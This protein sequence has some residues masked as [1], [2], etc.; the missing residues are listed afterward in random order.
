MAASRRSARIATTELSE[1]LTLAGR[2]YGNFYQFNDSAPEIGSSPLDTAGTAQ[3]IGAELRGRYEII[4]PNKLGI[5]AGAEASYNHTRSTAE[6]EGGT[7]GKLADDPFVYDVEGTYAEIDAQ[8]TSWLAFTGGIRHDLRYDGNAKLTNRVSPRLAVFF[9][10]PERYG[11]KLLY[12]E[13]FRNPSAFEGVFDDQSD[14]VANPD[15][16]PEWIRSF[17][18][19]AWAKPQPGI[20]LRLSGFYWGIHDVIEQRPDP[21]NPMLL[22]FQNITRYV[23]Q[24]I[25]GEGSYRD[26]RGWYAFGGLA[27]T[28]V[29]SAEGTK[30]VAYGNV[31]NAPEITASAGVSTPKLF[32]RVHVSA[33]IV[34]LGERPTRPD[35]TGAASPPSPAWAGWNATIYAP[36]LAGFE[37]TAGVRNILGTRDLVPAPGDYDRTVMGGATQFVVARVPGEGREV[38]VKIGYS[39]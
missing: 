9:A 18:V 37:V 39:Y 28:H 11:V 21:M 29:G 1:R 35:A 8:P 38:Y 6:L 25:E 2:I 12:A 34:V 22:Q 32:D 3:V 16:S 4:A 5:T 30:A 19:V 13:G 31:A 33:E 7:S 36:N 17:E 15:I 24:G 20:S 27:F 26:S 14:F 10:A 23:S